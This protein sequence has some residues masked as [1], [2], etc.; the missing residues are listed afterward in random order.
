MA[1]F[2]SQWE[3]VKG[4]IM[5]VF[6]EF[7]GS[8]IINAIT[9]ETYLCLIPKK[10][11]SCRVKDFRP[12]SLVTSLYK[13]IAKVLAKR[14][15]MVLGETISQSQ[16]A[17][18]AGRQILDVVLVANEAI[19]DYRRHNKEGWVVKIDFEKAY[20]NVCWDFLDLVLQ[21][22][23]FGLKWRSWIRGCLTSV[24]YSVLIN[25]R[26]RGKFKGYKGLRQGDPLSPFLFTLVADGLS[27][28]MD[29]AIETGFVKPWRVGR[30]NVTV[31]HLQFA[32]DT[33]F[34]L[35]S[36]EVSFKNLLIVLG[37]FC[38]ASGL[39]INMGKSTILGLGLDDD[40]VYSMAD[41]VGCEVG[42]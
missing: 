18:V 13:I 26:P 32:D 31:S 29:R 30:D 28:L 10:L 2:Q 37:L 4:D 27:R 25:G 20:D 16:G 11:N 41:S 12:I 34:F 36:E 22:K 15:Q 17:F 14:L 9:N 39:K 8:G 6:E 21:K 35:D 1:V 19:E 24:S 3:T 7:Y 42:T 38:S 5:K 40:M 33:I 23:N